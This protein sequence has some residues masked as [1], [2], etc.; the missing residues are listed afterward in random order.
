[1][2]LV[3]NNRALSII[4]L[5]QLLV[6]DVLSLPVHIKS[7]MLIFFDEKMRGAFALQKLLIFFCQKMATFLHVKI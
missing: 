2:S 4:I 1:M 7:S 3:L 6:K 5:Q